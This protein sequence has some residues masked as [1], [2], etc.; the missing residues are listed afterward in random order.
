MI[1]I[2]QILCLKIRQI[3]AT[4]I[5]C[6]LGVRNVDDQFI[7]FHGREQESCGEARCYFADLTVL[8]DDGAG[9]KG[10][11]TVLVEIVDSLGLALEEHAR[12]RAYYARPIN[13]CQQPVLHDFL[14]PT[15]SGHL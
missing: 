10:E 12:L 9:A 15:I 1:E 8:R 11:V 5:V 4:N 13:N 2:L 7:R 14:I 3:E 6:V